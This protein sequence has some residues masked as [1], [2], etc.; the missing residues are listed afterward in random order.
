MSKIKLTF[1]IYISKWSY[2]V[3][4]VSHQSEQNALKQYKINMLKHSNRI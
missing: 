2:L 1:K 3:G 4:A